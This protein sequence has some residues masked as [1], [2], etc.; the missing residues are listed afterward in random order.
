M[1]NANKIEPDIFNRVTA[2][3]TEF[4]RNQNSLYKIEKLKFSIHE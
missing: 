1:Y 2:A 4:L 3:M